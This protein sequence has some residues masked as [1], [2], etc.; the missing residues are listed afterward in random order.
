VTSEQKLRAKLDRQILESM[1]D[2]GRDARSV[3][4]AIERGMKNHYL[5]PTAL[6]AKFARMNLQNL[7]YHMSEIH[8]KKLVYH[9]NKAYDGYRLTYRGLD[10]LA[11]NCLVERGSLASFGMIIG[12]GKESDV[13]LGTGGPKSSTVVVKIHRLGRVS[14]TKA[15]EK[16]DYYSGDRPSSWMFISK[17]AA[18]KE[19]N[20]LRALHGRDFPVPQ[21]IDSNRHIVVMEYK[22]YSLLNHVQTLNKP[23]RTFVEIVNLVNRFL[24]NGIVHCDLNEFNLLINVDTG[25]LTV[26][27]FPQIISAKHPDA[28][29]MVERDLE[30]VRRFFQKRFKKSYNVTADFSLLP[31][32]DDKISN[33]ETNLG[34]LLKLSGYSNQKRD[35]E[36]R[37]YREDILRAESQ[38]QDAIDKG[39]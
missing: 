5:V 29:F 36:Y 12:K 38:W 33:D 24:A 25:E 37:R 10:A 30:C 16:R 14:F 35:D 21:P 20:H 17:L 32:N 1:R 31:T 13:Y 28:R 19:Y 27:D 11:I 8:R 6:I 7:K 39:L 4:A 34:V 9:E 22:P 15:R 23:K 3:L 18:Q 2:L 26:I